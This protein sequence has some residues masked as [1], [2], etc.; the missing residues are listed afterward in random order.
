MDNHQI[1]LCLVAARVAVFQEEA[2][3]QALP[4]GSSVQHSFR[5]NGL[6]YTSTRVGGHVFTGQEVVTLIED[7]EVLWHLSFWGQDDSHRLTDAKVRDRVRTA[8]F[9]GRNRLYQKGVI[10]G[11]NALTEGGFI[12][13]DNK[14]GGSSMTSIE[15]RESLRHES[16]THPIWQMRYRGGRFTI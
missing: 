5:Q 8:L 6:L 7:D 16:L 4:R 15:G 1:E 11:E 13:A 3:H 2:D 10:V 12:Y 14:F 9:N